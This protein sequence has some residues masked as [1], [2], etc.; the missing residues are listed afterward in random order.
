MSQRV[1]VR[2]FPAVLF[3]LGAWLLVLSGCVTTTDSRFAREADRAD[4]VENYVRL[5]SAYTSQ[6]S[7]DRARAHLDRALELDSKHA[8]ALAVQ[9]LLYQAEGEPELAERSFQQALSSDNGYTRG[10]V[11]YGAFL[12]NQ[13]NFEGARQQFELASRDTSY[14]DR[15]SVFFN[16][17]L[18]EERLTNTESAVNAYRRASELNRG[19]PRSLLAVSRVLV[20]LGE[21]SEASRYYSRLAGLI[22]RSPNLTHSPESLLTGIR[23]ARH[24]REYDQE[25]S[26]ALVL[27]NQ[28]PD[29]VEY[30]QYRAL[31]ADDN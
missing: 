10:R 3:L 30:R 5:A 29:S 24:F 12:Y 8:P 18:T 23:I 27:R 6:G 1:Q 16:L 17:G 13:R 20:Q 2:A 31:V 25:S 4:A 28:F 7:F 11:Y 15:G 19:D 26:L 21:Y 14:E 22:Q 9:G